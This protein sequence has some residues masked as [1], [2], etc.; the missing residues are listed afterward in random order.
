MAAPEGDVSLR[1]LAEGEKERSRFAHARSTFT[2]TSTT[3]EPHKPQGAG[4]HARRD[5]LL[6]IQ[7][8][9]QTLWDEERIFEAEPPAE[10][11]RHLTRDRGARAPSCVGDGDHARREP[12]IDAS[13]RRR[14]NRT[15]GH[16]RARDRDHVE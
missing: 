16:A 5:L 10:G 8:Q 15:K 2:S 6:K 4:S 3:I 11:E 12:S 13:Y 7:E 14:A 1:P 9:Q